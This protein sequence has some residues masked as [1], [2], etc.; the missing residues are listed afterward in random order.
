MRFLSFDK[1]DVESSKAR[2]TLVVCCFTTA[3]Y[4]SRDAFIKEKKKESGKK[5]TTWTRPIPSSFTGKK[6]TQKKQHPER[7]EKKNTFFIFQGKNNS[8][9]K[10]YN[11]NKWYRRPITAISAYTI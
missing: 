2:S 8:K 6:T 3:R 9:V 1:Y 5:A 7:K 4:I 10:G 11:G